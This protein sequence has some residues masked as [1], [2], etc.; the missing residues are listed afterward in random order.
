MVRPD[1]QKFGIP[2]FAVAHSMLGN[3]YELKGE[4]ELAIAEYQTAIRSGAFSSRIA[5]LGHAYAMAG[6]KNDSFM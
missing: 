3:A 6:R 2:N 1:N 4:Y 5:S